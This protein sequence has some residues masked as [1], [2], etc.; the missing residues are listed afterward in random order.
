MSRFTAQLQRQGFRVLL[1]HPERSPEFLNDPPSLGALLEEGNFTQITA[2]S[3]RGDF[4]RTVKRFSLAMLQERLVHVVA[5]DAHDAVK[6]PPDVLSIVRDVVWELALPAATAE[7]LTED[8]PRALL[9]DEPMPPVPQRQRRGR[10]RR[11]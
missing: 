4:G 2:G 6:R 9:D 10:R 1:A 3:L 7:F 11:R 8:C 5:S